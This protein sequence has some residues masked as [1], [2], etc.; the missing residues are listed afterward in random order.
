M[1][2][3]GHAGI[4]PPW[5]LELEAK[6]REASK[7]ELDD[8]HTQLLAQAKAAR[9]AEAAPTKRKIEHSGPKRRQRQRRQVAVQAARR[10]P[11]FASFVRPLYPF[12]RNPKKRAGPEDITEVDDEDLDTELVDALRDLSSLQD[13]ASQRRLDRIEALPLAQLKPALRTLLNGL[14]P[15]QLEELGA[16]SSEE[17]SEDSSSSEEP[18]RPPRPS[19]R[20][21]ALAPGRVRC[22]K[23]HKLTPML[24]RPPDYARH[25]GIEKEFAC[26]ICGS[27]YPLYD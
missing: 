12:H 13:A 14:T 27:K 23:G 7:T 6:T 25:E 5:L 19:G 9:A 16:T 22:S 10:Q 21:V 24:H 2:F 3:A 20:V 1:A 17:E 26:D 18:A 11:T 8:L 4:L 15:D